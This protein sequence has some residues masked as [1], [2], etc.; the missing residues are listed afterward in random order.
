M[1]GDRLEA[2]RR[3]LEKAGS[4]GYL[5][6]DGRPGYKAPSVASVMLIVP[7]L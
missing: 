4:K 1:V 3:L 5:P 6:I 7:P 2:E